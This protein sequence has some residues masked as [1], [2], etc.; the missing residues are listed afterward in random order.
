MRN[1]AGYA[2]TISAAFM[3]VVAIMLNS[4]SLFFMSTAL[5]VTMGASRLQAWFAVR[6]LRFDR[7]A[8]DSVRVGDLVTVEITVWS[9]RRL[10]RPLVTVIDNLDPRLPVAD[11]TVSLPV[12]PAFDEPIETQY[13][14]RP[15]RRGRYRWSGVTVEGTDALGIITRYREYSTTTAEMTVL[16]RPMPVSIDLPTFAGWGISEAESGQTRG[17]GIEPRGIRPYVSGDSLRHVHWRSTAR[18]GNLLVKEFEAGTH[19]A[20][21]FLFQ[22]TKGSDIGGP[23]HTTL[24]AMCGHTA[25]LAEQFLREGVNVFFPGLEEGASRVSVSERSNEIYELLARLNADKPDAVS[26]GLAD[27]ALTLAPGSVL[28]VLLSVQDPELPS[29]ISYLGVRGTTV[30]PLIYNPNELKHNKNIA[31]AADPDYVSKLRNAGSYPQ[32]MPTEAPIDA[33]R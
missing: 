21:A 26:N 33:I 23:I 2:L 17:A 30:V 7:V 6:E 15:M 18:T 28:F 14:F 11:R 32:L 16:P 24:E 31:S 8:P 29:T 25:Y 19:A 13:Q 5:V 10:R 20:A 27:A 3:A 22:L 12:A 9:E 4:P 1:I